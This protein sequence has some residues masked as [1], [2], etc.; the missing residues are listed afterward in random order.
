MTARLISLYSHQGRGVSASNGR[1]DCINLLTHGYEYLLRALVWLGETIYERGKQQ[2]ANR[3]FA[4][5]TRVNKQLGVSENPFD[6]A[7]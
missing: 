1:S 7:R 2:E 6:H 3:R 4:R 5:L